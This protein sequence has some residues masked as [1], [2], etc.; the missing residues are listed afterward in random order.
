MFD[1]N[2][3]REIEVFIQ[4]KS[5]KAVKIIS[6]SKN[7]PKSSVIQ[8]IEAGITDFGENRVQEAQ[9]KFLNLKKDFKNIE[10]HLTGPL[11]TNKVKQA[12]D[13][14]DVFQ[15]LDREKLAKEFFKHSEKIINKVFFIQINT[16]KEINKSG[17]F[18]E[19]ATE[20]IKY[21][22]SGLGLNIKGLMCIPPINDVPS[23]HFKFLKS[24]SKKNN[25]TKL[26]MGMSDDYEEAIECGATHIR[27]GTKL[28]GKRNVL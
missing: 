16:G 15:T 2:N 4:E 27:V 13:I 9:E 8:A 12:L 7:H 14:F 26:S 25:I 24:I 22:I 20:F 3:Y 28:F 10:L 1:I 19:D 17:I 11:Q 6:V 18:P 5:K 21:C 23:E